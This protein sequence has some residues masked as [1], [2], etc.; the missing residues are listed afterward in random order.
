MS[1]QRVGGSATGGNGGG[2]DGGRAGASDTRPVAEVMTTHVVTVP[3]DAPVAEAARLMRDHDIG[4][5]LVM[6]GDQVRG[7]V[8][9]RD[10]TIRAVA[11]GR[12]VQST[13]VSEVASEGVTTVSPDDTIDLAAETMRAE[14]LRRVVVAEGGRPVGILSLGDLAQ[15]DAAADDAGIALSDISGAPPQD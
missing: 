9:D 1:D 4:P 12:D 14:A 5:V 6:D 3:A 10:I 7:I 13:P 8:T 11:E 15:N 2:A